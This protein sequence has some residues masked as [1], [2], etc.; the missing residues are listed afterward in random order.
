VFPVFVNQDFTDGHCGI[1][2]FKFSCTGS[3]L[4]MCNAGRELNFPVVLEICR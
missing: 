1:M 3:K 2:F 4:H